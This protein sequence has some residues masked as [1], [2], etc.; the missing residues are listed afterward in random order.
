MTRTTLVRIIF[1]VATQGS[2][3]CDSPITPTRP[4]TA[5]NVEAGVII[6]STSAFSVANGTLSG[7]V[8]E[9]TPTGRVPIE[10]VIVANG[11]GGHAVT[12]AS[13]AYRIQELWVCPCAA[14][15]WVNAGT[16][17]LWIEKAGYADPVGQPPSIFNRGQP[18]ASS[19]GWRDVIINGD[20]R[21]DIQL[22]RG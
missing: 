15:P 10:G 16:T 4:S 5:L 11:E 2:F 19:V 12:D 21:F 20:T 13:G 18:D 6:A 3:G 9:I 22:V 8:T 7:F 17:F 1:L 14:Q